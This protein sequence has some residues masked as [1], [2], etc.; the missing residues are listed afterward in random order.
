MEK[1]IIKNALQKIKKDEKCKPQYNAFE[2]KGPTGPTGPTGPRGLGLNIL[3]TY[4]TLEE[5]IKNHPVGQNE[6]AYIVGEDLYIWSNNLNTWKNVG[7]I[8]GP[9]GK[10]GPQGEKGET[11]EKGEQGPTGPKGEQ[12]PRGLTGLVGPRGLDGEQ[13]KQG[14]TGPKGEQGP[15][16]LTGLVGPKG[17]DGEK[18]E[19]GPT[20]PKGDKGEQ[21]D[22]GPAGTVATDFGSKYQDVTKTINAIANTPAPIPLDKTGPTSNIIT[23]AS[24]AMNIKEEGVYK[25]DY[26]IS[27]KYSQA[28]QLVAALKSNLVT[29]PG[30]NIKETVTLG[31]EK[32]I[33]STTIAEL[34]K[35][36]SISV[37]ITSNVNVDITL[38]SETSAYLHIVRLK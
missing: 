1:D 29:I 10:E 11:G 32:V 7:R 6:D 12:G 3:S 27:A 19:Q 35:G 30:S 14:P 38:A 37:T 18:G 36:D 9:E 2:I 21:G 25:I 34:K 22:Q 16:G 26:Y 20:G 31:E 4:E 28:S 8:R 13:G 17:L 23:T 15:R 5:L 24:N 33:Q